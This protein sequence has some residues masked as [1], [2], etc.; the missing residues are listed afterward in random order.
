MNEVDIFICVLAFYSL[1]K[2]YNNG[3]FK[4]L[5]KVISIFLA[6]HI[7]INF[8]DIPVVSFIILFISSFIIL[9]AI[10]YLLYNITKLLKLNF[11]NKILGSFFNILKTFII[12]SF[13][14]SIEKIYPNTNIGITDLLEKNRSKSILIKPIEES[15]YIIIPK[16][17]ELHLE[18]KKFKIKQQKINQEV[19]D[20][21]SQR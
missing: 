1:I 5:T 19:K 11:F 13:L 20:K 8:S 4:E 21:F 9:K 14:F 2:G 12:L 10:S 6:I 18:T 17:E 3:F 7:A 15:S 16:L